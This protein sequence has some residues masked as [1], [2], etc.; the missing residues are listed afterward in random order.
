LEKK[1]F[2]KRL[3][4]LSTGEKV[5]VRHIVEFVEEQRLPVDGFRKIGRIC[6]FPLIVDLSG[7]VPDEIDKT[8]S[9]IKAIIDEFINEPLRNKT[10]YKK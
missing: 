1:L 6:G 3:H 4:E 2:N 8:Q 7:L 5:E 10:G 9:R